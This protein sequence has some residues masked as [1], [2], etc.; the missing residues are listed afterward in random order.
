MDELN[1]F[2]VKELKELG[3]TAWHGSAPEEFGV[4]GAGAGGVQVA[5]AE[6]V[7]AAVA[8]FQL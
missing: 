3:I 7:G 8:H 5:G 1:L 2:I 4:A 6:E